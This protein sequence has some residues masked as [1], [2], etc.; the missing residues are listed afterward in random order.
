MV[1]R[2][3]R[4]VHPSVRLQCTQLAFSLLHKL[5]P[6]E[7]E[8]VTFCKHLTVNSVR[9]SGDTRRAPFWQH[10]LRTRSEAAKRGRMFIC[11]FG[12]ILVSYVRSVHRYSEYLRTKFASIEEIRSQKKD[13]FVTLIYKS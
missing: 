6:L 1:F 2:I 13:F 3:D 11:F 4:M 9:C 10:S 7:P 5:I 8:R 12:L